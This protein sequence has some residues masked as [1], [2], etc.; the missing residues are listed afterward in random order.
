MRNSITY[1]VSDMS[2]AHCER[3]VTAEVSALPGVAAVSVDLPS[4]SV[5]VS[6]DALDD[7]A[8]RA[9]IA[10]AGYEAR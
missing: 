8:L 6:G 9:A 7:H 10:G 1:T 5:V 3:A 2:C 4:R